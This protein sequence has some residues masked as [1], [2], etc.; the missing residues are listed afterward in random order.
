MLGFRIDCI[1]KYISHQEFNWCE[2]IYCYIKAGIWSVKLLYYSLSHLVITNTKKNLKGN[3][4]VLVNQDFPLGL[5][6]VVSHQFSF[7]LS[8]FSPLGKQKIK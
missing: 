5:R 1:L 8:F 6:I 3:N 2:N 4:I 7:T